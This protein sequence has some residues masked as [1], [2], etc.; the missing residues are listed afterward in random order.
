MVEIKGRVCAQIKALPSS[1]DSSRGPF[2]G[3]LSTYGNI[4]LGGDI[5]E[6]GCFDR[7]VAQ[8]GTHRPLLWQH[9]D[10][11]PIGSFDVVSTEGT[12]RIKGSFNLD[13]Q[14][15]REGYSLL[16]HGDIDGLSIGY[17]A[18]DYS[19]D[20]DGVRH[21]LDVDLMEGSLVTF[22]MNPQARAEAKSRRHARMSRFSKCAFLTK[23]T[24]E[25]RAQALAELDEMDRERDEQEAPM[26]PAQ[27]PEQAPEQS[28]DA[29]P[30]EEDPK[31]DPSEQAPPQDPPAAQPS[32]TGVTEQSE[33]EVARVFR[34]VGQALIELRNL[35]EA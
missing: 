26:D 27:E 9:R 34:E 21:L 20:R 2:E 11:D 28:P 12:L 7:N 29:E 16:K 31:Q 25:E 10:D 19:Y 33:S 14:H 18:V 5:C 4:D 15:G 17:R 6:A 23:M 24:D 13:T 3:D 8:Q 32:N 1:P 22:P 35:M 30:A